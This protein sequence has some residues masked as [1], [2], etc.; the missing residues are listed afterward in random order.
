MNVDDKIY[1]PRFCTVTIK[2]VFGS[3][4]E[5]RKAGFTESAHYNDSEYEVMGRSI[6]LH[7]MEFAGVKKI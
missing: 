4:S 1:T 5:A 6:D 7:H 3:I 2:D